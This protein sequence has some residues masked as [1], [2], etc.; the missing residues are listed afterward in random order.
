[1]GRVP[2][3]SGPGC[4]MLV[5]SAETGEPGGHAQKRRHKESALIHGRAQISTEKAQFSTEL[6]Q[7]SDK[8]SA[9]FGVETLPDI[10]HLA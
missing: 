8:G 4:G 6:C 3:K 10:E 1:M 7:F 2:V 5:N 9:G